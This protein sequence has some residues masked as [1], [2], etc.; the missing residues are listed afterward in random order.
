MSTKKNNKIVKNKFL[1]NLALLQAKKFLGKT[2]INPSVGCII[3]NKK[4]ELLSLSHTGINGRPHAEFLALRK[5]KKKAI[6]STLYVTLEPCSHYGQTAPCTKQIIK[7]KVNKVYFSVIDIDKITSNKAKKILNTKN[8]HTNIGLLSGKVKKFY[9]YYYKNRIHKL[10]FVTCK[11][12]MSK[13]GFI[14]NIS[15]KNISNIY[16][17]KISN[18]LRSQNNAILISSKTANDDNPTLN[19]RVE[20]LEKF[21]PKRII[22]DKNLKIKINS[23]IVKTSYDF[24]TIIFYN[25]I[26]TSKINILKKRKINLYKI[27]LNNQ[28]NLDL[29]EILKKIY[30]L[31]V[32]RLLIEGGKE[33]TNSFMKESLIDELLLFKSNENL[34]SKGRLNINNI[35]KMSNKKSKLKKKVIVNLEDD[36][37]YKYIF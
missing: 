33:L 6:N 34:G 8:I 10:P 29:K 4:K 14:K 1:M 36:N 21:S 17:R 26:N 15:S 16:S 13:D 27:K 3:L 23:K 5:L 37:L 11:I 22:L 12:A 35:I 7:K 20:G 18:I 30:K 9:Q 2:G 19:C 32:S 31:N 24:K 25:K 28:N